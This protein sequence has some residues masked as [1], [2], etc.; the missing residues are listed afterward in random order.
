V[1][2]LLLGRDGLLVTSLY[3]LTNLG[4]RLDVLWDVPPG[5]GLEEGL[6]D[7]RGFRVHLADGR[8]LGARLVG[9]DIRWGFALLR[10]DDPSVGVPPAPVPAPASSLQRGRMVVA[11]GDPFGARRPADPLLTTGILSKHH[12]EEIAAPWRGAWQTDA[13]VTDGNAGGAAVDLEGRLLGMLTIWDPARH[14]RHS[15]VAFIVPWSRIL[16]SVPGLLHGVSPERGL[17]GVRFRSG[18]L[19]VLGTIVPDSAAARAGLQVGDVLRTIDGR[20]VPTIPDAMQSIGQ[21]MKGERVRVSVER[22]GRVFEHTVTLGA[23]SER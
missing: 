9:H 6:A 15:G 12:E 19:P 14:G 16:Q 13:G 20:R 17:L 10:L 3:D 21:R 5:A 23:R 11:A 7:V 4:E 1:T 8:T 22:A 18:V 2:G